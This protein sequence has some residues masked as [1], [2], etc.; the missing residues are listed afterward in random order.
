MGI[1]YGNVKFPMSSAL[2][3]DKTFIAL[4]YTKLH[5]DTARHQHGLEQAQYRHPYPIPAPPGTV[6][7]GRHPGA[8]GDRSEKPPRTAGSD[9]DPVACFDSDDVSLKLT[10]YLSPTVR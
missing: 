10:Y 4:I 3:G 9:R 2:H 6:E 1:C 5:Q 7:S 8:R